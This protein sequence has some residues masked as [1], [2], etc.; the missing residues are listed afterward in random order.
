VGLVYI[1]LAT[2]D[3]VKAEEYRFLG[4]R[5]QVR[6][7]AAQMALDKVRRHLIS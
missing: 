5:S 3:G 4:T 7:R 1:A 2:K 6:Q